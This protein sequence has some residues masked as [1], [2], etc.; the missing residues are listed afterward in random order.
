M[1]PVDHE[2]SICSSLHDE[3]TRHPVRRG[4]PRGRHHRAR[5]PWRGAHLRR[6][7]RARAR[8]VP[9]RGGDR[10]RAQRRL[11]QRRGLGVR[12]A[13]GARSRRR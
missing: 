9:P 12:A 3:A 10:G 5:A 11:G 7:Q 8:G 13:A 6:R 2:A 4:G 1:A